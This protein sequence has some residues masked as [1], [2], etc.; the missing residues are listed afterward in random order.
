MSAAAKLPWS[1]GAD[2]WPDEALCRRIITTDPRL[3][4]DS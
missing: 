2:R 1:S 3:K 4:E